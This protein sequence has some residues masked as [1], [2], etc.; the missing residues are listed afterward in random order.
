MSQCRCSGNPLEQTTTLG[1]QRPTTL[2]EQRPTRREF[3]SVGALSTLG[4][5]LGDLLWAEQ[6]R[7]ES[8]E[9]SGPAPKAKS[10]IHIFLPG[11][12]AHQESFDPKPLAPLEYRGSFKAIDTKLPGVQFCETLPRLAQIADKLTVIRSMTHGEAAHERGTHNMFTGYK[13]SPAIVYPSLGSV[14]S[15]ELGPRQNLPPYI[16]I[17]N[18]PNPYAGTGYLGSSFG[19]FGLG[20]D[21]ASDGFQVRD[22]SLPKGVD[23]ARFAKRRSM[24]DAVNSHFASLEKSDAIDAMDTFYQRAYSLISSPEAR[25]AFQIDKEP[26]T[27]R[28]QYGRNAAGQRM[29]LARRLVEA[30]VRIV[31]LTYGSWDMHRN[32]VPGFKRQAP[33]LDVALATLIGDLEQRGMLD[34]TLVML[35]SE[36]GR[37]PKINSDAGRDHFPRVFSI[38]LAGGGVKRGLVY[39]SSSATASEV[40]NDPIGP[41]DLFATVYHLL[42]V[43]FEKKLIAAGNRPIDIV[44]NGQPRKELLV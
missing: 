24:L 1:E 43:E 20:A 11:G 6:A 3:L 26:D 41:A 28:D 12:I 30:G 39:G 7:A 23:D 4:L 44:R 19:P 8:G 36:F 31:T 5:S 40:E 18:Q 14:V 27:L 15:H 22:L 25:A 16:C 34:D 2:G 29:L 21:P 17:P 10:V 38:A 9:S 37:T 33:D 32:I 42:G 13:P 35:S